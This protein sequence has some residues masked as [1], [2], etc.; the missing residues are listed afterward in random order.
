M[1]NANKKLSF[2]IE[3]ILCEKRIRSEISSPQSP[4]ESIDVN[5]NYS[6]LMRITEIQFLNLCRNFKFKEKN[7][8]WRLKLFRNWLEP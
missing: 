2:S 7:K 3:D 5:Y 4:L 6:K 8:L 1:M